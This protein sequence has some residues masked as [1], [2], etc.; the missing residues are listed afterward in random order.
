MIAKY[1]SQLESSI[2]VP[3]HDYS[4]MMCVN[5]RGYLM[6]TA[7][8]LGI[9]IPKTCFID[10]LNVLRSIADKIDFPAVIKLKK[11]TSSIG[12]FTCILRRK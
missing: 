3:L 8:S 1:R 2:K 12:F 4:T 9:P 10:D 6:Q 5:D 7:N 11:M